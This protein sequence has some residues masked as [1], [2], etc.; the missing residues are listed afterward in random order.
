MERLTLI[1]ILLVAACGQPAF[2]DPVSVAAVSGAIVGVQSFVAGASIGASIALAVASF[3]VSYYSIKKARDDAKKARGAGGARARKTMFRQAITSRKILYGQCNVSGPIVFLHTTDNDKTMHIVVAI[4]THE[5][6]R[7][8]QFFANGSALNLDGD[9]TTG[10]R[11]TAAGTEVGDRYRNKLFIRAF[12][13]ADDQLA[14]QELIDAAP[15]M[16]DM[17]RR[18]RGIAY[19]YV[20]L[21]QD[22]DAFPNGTPNI[23]CIVKGKMIDD[24]RRPLDAEGNLLTTQADI[25]ARFAKYDNYWSDNAALV[26]YDYLRYDPYGMGLGVDDIDY[27]SFVVGANLADERQVRVGTKRVLLTGDSTHSGLFFSGYRIRMVNNA[28]RIRLTAARTLGDARRGRFSYTDSADDSVTINYGFESRYTINGVVDTAHRPK[29]IIANMLLA[30]AA[31]FTISNGRIHLLPANYPVPMLT[32]TEKD[33][34]GRWAVTP[35]VSGQDRFNAVKGTHISPAADWEE[36]D[37]PIIT[38]AN[39]MAEDGGRRLTEELPL[40]YTLS[41]SMAQRLANLHLLEARQELTASIVVNLKG[42]RVQ[43][44]DTIKITKPVWGFNEKVFR[45]ITF[46]I[47]PRTNGD[48]TA[49]VCQM[50]LK[51]TAAAVYNWSIGSEVPVDITPNTSF[52]DAFI[53]AAPRNV[54]ASSGNDTLFVAG[55]GTVQSRIRV[56]WDTPIDNKATFFELRWLILLNPSQDVRRIRWDSVVL[57]KNARE[58]FIPNVVGGAIYDIQIRSVSSLGVRSDYHQLLH[59]A[60]GKTEPPPDV[61]DLHVTTSLYGDRVFSFRE[62]YWPDDVRVGGGILIR[63]SRNAATAFEDMTAVSTKINNSP[64]ETLSIEEGTYTFAA[65]LI[66]SSGNLSLGTHTILATIGRR[67]LDTFEFIHNEARDNFPGVLGNSTIRIG[68]VVAAGLANTYDGTWS[69]QTGRPVIATTWGTLDRKW[70]ALPYNGLSMAYTTRVIDLGGSRTFKPLVSITGEGVVSL[71]RLTYGLSG[72][73]GGVN[74]ITDP[75]NVTLTEGTKGAT[76]TA[77]F[78]RLY[79]GMGPDTT[80]SLN[81][82]IEDIIISGEAT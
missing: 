16:W 51:E 25:A 57:P 73:A 7:F 30:Q 77:R 70:I 4:A 33:A 9:V 20:R 36:T 15:D 44:G 47:A 22:A 76:I 31:T 78:I 41:S 80:N 60:I 42:L 75:T 26:L 39:F 27:A 45:V 37:Y 79:V 74:N 68:N 52:P 69:P 49:L 18:L 2:A 56:V 29:G 21:I 64:Y 65:K 10:L 17:N 11:T 35:K 48:S 34:V 63:Y 55:D 54:V 24:I 13:G 67:N 32:F 23:N 72:G 81:A 53:I 28:P 8:D 61:I 5:I 3:A 14:C 38:H 1:L 12:R 46:D 82:F 6:F 71:I 40:D 50:T 59:S 43:V 66:D 58:Y 19:F 62:D